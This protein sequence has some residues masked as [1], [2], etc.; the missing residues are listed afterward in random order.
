[1]AE[2]VESY[3]LFE[4]LKELGCDEIQG[5]CVSK[6]IALEEFIAWRE[7]WM[8]SNPYTVESLQKKG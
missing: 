3:A 2:G 4:S 5:Y 8:Q 6:P 1:M 7:E